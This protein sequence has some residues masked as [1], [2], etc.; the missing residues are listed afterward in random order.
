MIL[1]QK[2]QERPLRID[3]RACDVKSY[4]NTSF[5]LRVHQSV[6]FIQRVWRGSIE[7]QNYLIKCHAITKIQRAVRNQ[8]LR[9]KE[10]TSL[11]NVQSMPNVD[12]HVNQYQSNV[13][14]NTM[15]FKDNE[16]DEV[17][18]AYGKDINLFEYD[19]PHLNGDG[20]GIDQ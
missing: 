9:P 12:P 19:A 4:Q 2:K 20:S 6:I 15:I 1:D 17:A 7:R 10:T 14:N 13:T 11:V 3:A 18:E 5:L 16:V 8:L